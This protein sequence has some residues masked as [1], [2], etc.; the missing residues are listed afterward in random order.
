M[1]YFKDG[2]WCARFVRNRYQYYFGRYRSEHTAWEVVNKALAI[3]AEGG[4]DAVMKYRQTLDLA[5]TKIY[6]EPE[7][8][9]ELLTEFTEIDIVLSHFKGGGY[10][11]V[12]TLVNETRLEADIVEKAL[13]VLLENN[14]I[15]IENPEAGINKLYYLK[16]KT[17][18]RQ[19]KL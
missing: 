6:D 11:S 5:I 19:K 12:S 9:D 17:K 10:K 4:H 7:T 13:N 14:E 1:V 3:Y 18:W 15:S 2:R 16:P 8:V